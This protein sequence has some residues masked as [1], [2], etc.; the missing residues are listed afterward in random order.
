M[1]NK[2]KKKYHIFFYL[3]RESGFTLLEI[4]VA[5]AIISIVLISVY[6]MHAQTIDMH[7]TARFYSTAPMLAESK[8]AEYQIKPPDEWIEGS[9]DFGDQFPGYLWKAVFSDVESEALGETAKDIKR[10]DITL[11]FNDG[12]F[13]YSIRT[14]MMEK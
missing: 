12:E 1:G 11:S 10:L 7:Y 13:I 2:I 6:R 5:V 9:G 3:K 14:Y 4:M 8:I